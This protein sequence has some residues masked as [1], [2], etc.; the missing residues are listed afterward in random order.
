[1]KTALFLGLGL[2]LTAPFFAVQYYPLFPAA[3]MPVTS[4]DELIPLAQPAVWLYVSLYVQITLPLL[5]SRDPRELRH[6]CFGFGWIVLVSHTLFLFWPT[7]IPAL[8]DGVSISDPLLR[9][10]V[11]IQT[12]RSACP[13]LHASL[14]VYCALS[15]ARLL[16]SR[17]TRL[18]LWIW[19]ALILASTLL[20]KQHVFL[21]IAAGSALGAAAYG[22]LFRQRPEEPAGSPAL[23]A[24]LQARHQLA[25]SLGAQLD[26]LSSLDWRRRAGDLALFTGLCA[27]GMYLASRGG[28]LLTAAG[29]GLAALGLNA[30]VLLMH[31]G[32]HDCLFRGRVANRAGSVLLG[33]TFLMSFSAYRVLHTRH[34]SYLGDSRDPDDYRNYTGRPGLLWTLHFVRL[35]CGSL[36][37][38]ALIPIL[39]LKYGTDRERRRILTEYAFLLA[40]YCVTLRLVPASALLV[41]WWIP[42]LIVGNLTSIRGFAQHGITD[43]GDP[44]IASRTMLPHP[45]VEFFVLHEN[46]HLEHHLF[47]E[48]PSYHLPRLHGL[49]WPKA[50]RAVSGR[51]YLQFLARF[52]RA[53]ARLDASPIGLERP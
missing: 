1:M 20:A 29:I 19:T 37:Y 41:A 40:V 47:P 23:E 43:A 17:R 15:A 38:L 42:L 32:M 13:S 35:V 26:G 3:A 28:G 51:G 16:A 14:A 46:Y 44:Y 21:D 4:L 24:T 11:E 50:P 25:A 49:V 5:L 9:L 33:A 34:H 27:A 8:L 53:T 45:I 12:D 18:F 31:E 6:M 7:A 30:F 48:I 52:F 39:A 36:L 22:A 10:V 2:W